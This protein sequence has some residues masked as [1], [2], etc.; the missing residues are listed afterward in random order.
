MQLRSWK[1]LLPSFSQDSGASHSR[2]L[3]NMLNTINTHFVSLEKAVDESV[4]K[5]FNEMRLQNKL[6]EVERDRV[7][8]KTSMKIVEET[9]NEGGKIFKSCL[10]LPKFTVEIDQQVRDLEGKLAGI[11][12]FLH[13][14]QF[15]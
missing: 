5:R 2:K 13:T 15:F 3:K 4:H 12:H 7:S 14:N 10:F 11:G 9:L 6:K 8:L 1:K